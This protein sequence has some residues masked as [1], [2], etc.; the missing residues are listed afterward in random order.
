MF[1]V[2]IS[3]WLPI[4]TIASAF[5]ERVAAFMAAN[6]EFKRISPNEFVSPNASWPEIYDKNA[7]V[8]SFWKVDLIPGE[9]DKTFIVD[10]NCSD[11]TWSVAAPDRQGTMR[12]IIWAQPI[13][14]AHPAYVKFFCELDYAVESE[15]W[16]CKKRAVAES[17]KQPSDDEWLAI[18]AK[19]AQ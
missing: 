5:D 8:N 4:E 3:L 9:S 11:K 2:S 17:N 1:L 18:N 6:R 15:I 10:A 14:E 12:Y 13:E 7:E 19:C 16:L